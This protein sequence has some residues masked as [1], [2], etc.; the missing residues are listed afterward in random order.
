MK[1]FE[2]DNETGDQVEVDEN[3]DP[4]AQTGSTPVDSPPTRKDASEGYSESPPTPRP[5]FPSYINSSIPE[6]YGRAPGQMPYSGS[7]G[8]QHQFA[9]QD[10]EQPDY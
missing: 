6:D 9:P 10:T 4:V 8:Q 3:G 5:A 1:I 7:T 2:I